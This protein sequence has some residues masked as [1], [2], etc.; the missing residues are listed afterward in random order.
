[1]HRNNRESCEEDMLI[2]LSLIQFIFVCNSKKKKESLL[3]VFLSPF[4]HHKF[5]NK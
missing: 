4:I 5:C 1:M 3:F 2:I